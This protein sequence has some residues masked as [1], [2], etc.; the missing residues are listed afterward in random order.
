MGRLNRPMDVNSRLI[1]PLSRSR[2]IH[3]YTRISSLTQ[4]GTRMSTMKNL[5][6]RTRATLV[7]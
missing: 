3:P 7:I 5:P 6:A 2:M 4:K 1:T